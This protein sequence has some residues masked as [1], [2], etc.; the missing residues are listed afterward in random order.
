M[1]TVALATLPMGYAALW[2][3]EQAAT[4]PVVELA[5]LVARLEADPEPVRW[6][7]AGGGC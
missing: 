5:R 3:P 2:S 1:R 4:G 6:V 7:V